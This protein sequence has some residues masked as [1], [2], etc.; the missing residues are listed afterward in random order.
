MSKRI[1]YF[2]VIS[3]LVFSANSLNA[4]QTTADDKTGQ[5][6]A[7]MQNQMTQMHGQM[8][9]IRQ[10]EDPQKKKV[11]MQEHMQSM[12][13]CMKT[14]RGMD[15]GMMSGMKGH[16]HMDGGMMTDKPMSGEIMQQRMQ[17]MD[18]RMDMMQSMME[19]MLEHQ[20]QQTDMMQQQ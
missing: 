19:Q 5:A 7:D 14:M 15:T 8:E 1:L 6:M 13:E 17:T 9:A 4:G 11:L 3:A 18:K 2:L 16:G 10:T 12:L 20:S